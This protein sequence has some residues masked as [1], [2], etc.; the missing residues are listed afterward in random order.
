MNPKED[1]GSFSKRDRELLVEHLDEVRKF[2]RML[3]V[4]EKGIYRIHNDPLK[5]TTGLIRAGCY[6]S[7]DIRVDLTRFDS[8]QE[9]GVATTTDLV[10]V[11]MK[12]RARTEEV[13]VRF[14]RKHLRAA[15]FR[16][17]LAFGAD[18]PEV[19]R[20]VDIVELGSTW[21]DDELEFVSALC[22]E[23]SCYRTL[24]RVPKKGQ[25][26]DNGAIWTER[27]RFLAAIEEAPIS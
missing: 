2:L 22:E 26:Y 25:T 23:R 20:K 7:C 4:K 24:G 11:D 17:L 15:T 1:I 21:I 8:A 18:Y 14:K 9:R 6:N 12:R 19:Q 10:L 27:S 13:L 16:E 5:S 3:L